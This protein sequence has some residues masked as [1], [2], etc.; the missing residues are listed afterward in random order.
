MCRVNPC[1]ADGEDRTAEDAVFSD[2]GRA[3]GLG[4][5]G[6]GGDLDA[7]ACVAVPDPRAAHHDYARHGAT[8]LFAAFNTA[9][10]TVITLPRPISATDFR[11]GTLVLLEPLDQAGGFRHGQ[12]EV[13]PV[14]VLAVPHPD[15]GRWRKSSQ[16]NA[17][18]VICSTAVSALAPCVR[19][20]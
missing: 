4:A 1:W 8:S 19:H 2:R 12:R 14:R 15:P 3:G 17:V 10:G 20:A 11:R 7:G 9:D 5:W 16:L 6:A 13:A 18:L